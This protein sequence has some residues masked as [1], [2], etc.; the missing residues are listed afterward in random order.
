MR[1][2][3]FSAAFL[4]LIFAISSIAGAQTTQLVLGPDSK[5]WIDGTS[6]KSDWSVAATEMQGSVLLDDEG[7]PIQATLT[8]AAEKIE[9]NRS[10][11]MDRLMYRAL[12]TKANPVITYT[13]TAMEGSDG[14][15]LATEGEIQVAGVTKPAPL[16]V[17]WVPEDGG[18]IR[19]RG[20]H[21]MKMTD[22][23]M[24]PPTAMFGALHT[25]DDVMVYFDVVFTPESATATGS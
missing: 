14:D 22:H 3:T 1:F 20:A 5:L 13:M 21:P 4:L 6:N 17:E 24:K 2:K 19:V 12:K 7:Q 25:A 23:G 8:V 9:S 15:S 10:K 11:I 16:K 18:A